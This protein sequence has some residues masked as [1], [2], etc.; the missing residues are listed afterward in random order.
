MRW[1]EICVYQ[2][3]SVTVYWLS[4]QTNKTRNTYIVSLWH[5]VI[6]NNVNSIQKLV[7][8][9]SEITSWPEHKNAKSSHRQVNRDRSIFLQMRA[10]Q[11]AVTGELIQPAA[12]FQLICNQFCT[13]GNT[14][15]IIYSAS[16]VGLPPVHRVYWISS[17]YDVGAKPPPPR[18][19]G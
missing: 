17:A 8:R 9:V 11:E 6:N 4:Q 18:R 1:D 7:C 5:L 10:R 14:C 15:A 16:F 19:Q 12:W 13:V 2:L 3:T